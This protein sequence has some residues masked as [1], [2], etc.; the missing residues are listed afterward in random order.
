MLV[1]GFGDVAAFEMHAQAGAEQRLLDVVRGQRVA[2]E[3]HVDVAVADELAKVRHAAGMHDGRSA[4]E[5]SLA[6]ACASAEQL[7]GDLPDGHALGL[8][9][10]DGAVHELERLPL[11]RRTLLGKHAHTAV[12]NDQRRTQLHVA[13]GHA[14]CRGAARLDGDTAVH[15]LIGDVDPMATDSQLG[16]LVGGAVKPLGKS[17]VHV[18]WHQLA[19]LLGGWRSPVVADLRK[20]FAQQLRVGRA[21]FYQGETRIETCLADRDLLDLESSAG[22]RNQ[23]EN[24]GQDQAVDDVPADLHVFDE[25]GR[26]MRCRRFGFHLGQVPP[27]RRG[28]PSSL[29]TRFASGCPAW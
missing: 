12:P 24:L 23:I 11:G 10:R 1:A 16:P 3:Q 26:N 9:G 25:F 2:G 4:D 18:G 17:A 6:A 27:V 14:A 7:V 5:Q 22:R 13:H 29:S 19:I 8:F 28:K 15:F 20:D 21:D